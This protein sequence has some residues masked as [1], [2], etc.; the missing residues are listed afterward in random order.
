MLTPVS[1]TGVALGGISGGI[2]TTAT[3]LHCEHAAAIKGRDWAGP[4]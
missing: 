3:C 2:D 4:D 1:Y